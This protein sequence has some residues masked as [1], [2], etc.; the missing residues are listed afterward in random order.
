MSDLGAMD[1]AITV[2][3]IHGEDPIYDSPQSVVHIYIINN[4][5]LLLYYRLYY[6]RSLSVRVPLDRDERANTISLIK[7]EE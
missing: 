3:V 4:E 6:Q 5:N 1:H 7:E 2:S